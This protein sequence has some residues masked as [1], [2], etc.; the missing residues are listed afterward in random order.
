MVAFLRIY[1]PQ[2]MHLS[3]HLLCLFLFRYYYFYYCF[4]YGTVG[5]CFLTDP[6][7]ILTPPFE[8]VFLFF[9][10]VVFYLFFF[11]TT[12]NCSN[13][14][15]RLTKNSLCELLRL[16]LTRLVLSFRTIFQLLITLRLAIWCEVSFNS[17]CKIIGL[18]INVHPF[19]SVL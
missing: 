4:F 18:V 2:T 10:V 14:V 6:F 13:C 17:C 9:F 15:G 3:T 16:I 12:R 11:I 19:I 7:D 5:F 1:C 8:R